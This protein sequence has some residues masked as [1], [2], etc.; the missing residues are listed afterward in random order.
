MENFFL[1]PHREFFSSIRLRWLPK[2]NSKIE[3]VHAYNYNYYNHS[4]I[5]QKL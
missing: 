2:A 5:E 3:D 4:V 1:F